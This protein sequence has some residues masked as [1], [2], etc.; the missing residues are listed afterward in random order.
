M[1][2]STG[3]ECVKWK[4]KY[5][6]YATTYLVIPFCGPSQCDTSTTYNIQLAGNNL[7]IPPKYPVMDPINLTWL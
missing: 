5:R 2:V 1:G 6:K 7:V 4:P 3:F